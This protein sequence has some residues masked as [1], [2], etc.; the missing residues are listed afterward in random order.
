MEI[1]I[2]ASDENLQIEDLG[3]I[4][5]KSEN[6]NLLDNFQPNDLISSV[7]LELQRN[8]YFITIDSEPVSYSILID[9][10]KYLTKHDHNKLNILQ[11]NIYLGNYFK[12]T[13]QDGK[14]KFI[15]Y[16]RDETMSDK[17]QE[18]EIVRDSSG[19]VGQ[20]ITRKFND[21][22]SIHQ[23]LTQSLNRN[24]EGKVESISTNTL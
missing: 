19:K 4:L 22:G 5:L 10:L 12:V 2:T 18:D 14:S 6:I 17:I 15:T 7:D 16:Y 20:I 9:R 1:I 21:D 13:K 8:K 11:H 24:T 23:E 3:V